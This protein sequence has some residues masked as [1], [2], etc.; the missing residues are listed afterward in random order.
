MNR[1]EFIPQKLIIVFT[2]LALVSGL[3]FIPKSLEAESSDPGRLMIGFHLP[4]FS[5]RS[6]FSSVA[7][8]ESVINHK[9][10]VQLY[11]QSW[12]NSWSDFHPDKAQFLLDRGTIPL[13]T[14]EPWEIGGTAEENARF[15]LA[16][17]AS[18]QHD[19]YLRRFARAVKSV[20]G[21]IWLRPMHEMN[22]NW[23]PWG[24]G[25]NG[26]TPQD[27][28]Q[29]WRH[30]V[31]LFREEGVTNV[32]WV[33]SPNVDSIPNESWN[34][35]SAY[36]PGDAYVDIIGLDGYNYGTTRS[37]SN[38]RS[39]ENIFSA[40]Y[41][42]VTALSANKPIV[43]AETAST[44]IGGDKAEWI[45]SLFA[46]VLGKFERIIAVIWFNENKELDW[47]I[48]SSSE[49]LEAFKSSVRDI[50]N[51]QF[52]SSSSEQK[53]EVGSNQ[54]KN[55]SDYQTA[56]DFL[57]RQNIISGYGDG[58]IRPNRATTR[59]E[60]AKI[61]TLSLRLQSKSSNSV[62]YKDMSTKHWAFPYIKAVTAAGIFNGLPGGF[63]K[64][65]REITRAELA[66]VITIAFKISQQNTD[67]NFRDVSRQ[68]W[69]SRFISSAVAVKLVNGFPDGTFRPDLPSSRGETFDI[70]YRALSNN[71]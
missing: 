9:I 24:A 58:S 40:A 29:A 6:D 7:E 65:D 44:E 13:L 57:R 34:T 56:I 20:N 60:L 70:V 4:A 25:V 52:G 61:I 12:G 55:E 69:A 71:Q 22:G 11:Y 49:S 54:S 18:G 37:W 35:I 36:W 53:I 17:I 51:T 59:A 23:Y 38:W 32:R 66:K 39:F 33:W 27:F 21:T 1:K 45:R 67:V 15:K 26:N 28:K 46:T 19:A 42:E 41:R 68:H 48:E 63:F 2:C 43:V 64:P 5:A 3:F 31:N 14:W 47:R 30:I 10:D 16:N 8:M 62:Y 50:G